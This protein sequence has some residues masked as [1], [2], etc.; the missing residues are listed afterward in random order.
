VEHNQIYGSEQN[1]DG[2][3]DIINIIPFGVPKY[4]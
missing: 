1:P 3:V 2:F 4:E